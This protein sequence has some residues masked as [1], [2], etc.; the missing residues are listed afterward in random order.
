M[1]QNSMLGEDMDNEKFSQLG[2][3]DSIMSQNEESLLSEMVYHYQDSS[4][5]FGVRKLLNKVHRD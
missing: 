5:A 2:G 1:R 4:K 3:G